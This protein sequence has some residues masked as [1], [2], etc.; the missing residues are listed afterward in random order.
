MKH[1][2]LFRFQPGYMNE[3]VLERG[4][5]AFEQLRQALPDDI[6]SVELRQNI[7]PREG[8]FDLAVEMDLVAQAALDIYLK[9]PIHTALVQEWVPHLSGRASIDYES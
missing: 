7:V 3:Q 5:N 4:R 1:I 8:N 2:V 6:R 9:H